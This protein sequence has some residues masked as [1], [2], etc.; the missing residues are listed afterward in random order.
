GRFSLTDL[1]GGAGVGRQYDALVSNLR[2]GKVYTFASSATTPL[3]FG[4]GTATHLIEVDGATGALTSTS[5]AL[6]PAITMGSGSGLFSGYERAGVHTG[7]RFFHIQFPSG[8]VTDLGPVTNPSR[9][10]CESWAYWGT[11]EFFGGVLY[12][13]YVQNSTTI[14]R[15]SIPTGTVSALATF[16]NL[17]DMC[18]FTI[19]PQRNR[20]Y[21]HHEGASQFRGGDETVGFCNAAWSSPNDTFRIGALTSASC[22]TAEH[23]TTTGDDR[24]GIAVSNTHVFYTGDS[25]TGRFSAADLTG[26]ARTASAPTQV[27][28]FAQNLRDGSIYAFG[29]ASGILPFGGGTATSLLEL[30]GATGTFTGRSIP[31][32]QPIAMGSGTGIFSGWNRVAVHASGRVFDVALPTGGVVDLGAMAAP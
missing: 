13:D 17:S 32:S 26:P 20:W 23:N 7:T 6:S 4:G 15:M 2:T 29:G 8:A 30:D 25:A 27:D 16:T 5:I 24:G 18:T 1:S 10:G 28:A 12:I 3:P 11:L 9:A 14:A 31:L 19:Q 21:F 22:E